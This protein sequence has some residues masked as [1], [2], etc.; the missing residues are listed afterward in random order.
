MKFFKIVVF[1]AMAMVSSVSAQAA[2]VLSNM[3]ANGLTDTSGTLSTDITT[4]GLLASGFTTGSVAQQLD[5]VSLVVL[6]NG[7][8]T[9]T[10]ALYS[11]NGAG[12]PGSSLATSTATT[13]GST[14]GVYTFNFSGNSL[15]ANTQY[16][17][18]PETGLKWYRGF[19]DA[20]PTAQNGSGFTFAGVR[21][22]QDSGGTWAV[23]SQRY[24]I[25]VSS[26]DVPPPPSA[27][28]EPALTSLLCF[29]GIAL[30]RR[31]MKK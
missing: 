5:W 27:I 7:S 22:S 15:T 16:W 19:S 17:I 28:P 24:N 14:K 3:G 8:A 13:V 1:A 6:N 11:N 29:G 9:K 30:I 25:S 10:V 12:A 20:D 2:V 21:R 31:R 18:L 26:S 4:G 23:R